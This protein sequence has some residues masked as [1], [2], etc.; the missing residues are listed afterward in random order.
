VRRLAVFTTHTPV[1]AGHD[2]FPEDMAEA[3]LGWMREALGL[4]LDEFMALG[5]T[6]EE[7]AGEVVQGIAEAAAEDGLLRMNVEDAVED[8]FEVAPEPTPPHPPAPRMLGVTPLS[9]RM[10]RST[11]GVSAKHGEVS[12]AMWQGLFPERAGDVPIHHVTNGVHARS[13]ISPLLWDLYDRHLGADWPSRVRDRDFWDRVGEIPNAELWA[14][15]Q[16]LKERLVSYA[17]HRTAQTMVARGDS[18][19]LV[20]EAYELFDP[21]ALTIGFARRFAGYKRGDLLFH[22]ADR[23]AELLGD[24]ERPVQVLFAGKAHPNDGEGKGIMRRVV[25]L[26]REPRFAKWIVFLEDYD[27][28]I[29][30]HLVRGVDVWLNNP[31]RPLEAS[32]TSGQKVAVNGGLN[33]SVLDGWWLEGYD[34]ANGWAIGGTEA[35]LAH[36]EEDRR[37]AASLYELLAGEVLPLYYDREGGVPHGWVEMMKR[38]IKTLTPVYNTDRMVAE[39]AERFYAGQEVG[40]LR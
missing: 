13:W 36:D 30:R 27:I 21:R 34:G 16:I 23:L 14:V 35:G 2:E 40:S 20:A 31:R 28:N 33:L 39:Y 6:R 8:E 11:N 19:E 22:D 17:R 29:A 24:P 10:A 5:D 9:I 37:D 38:S 12:R 15:H 32:G 26:A 18:P 3:Y 25:E 1:P 4:S 7:A